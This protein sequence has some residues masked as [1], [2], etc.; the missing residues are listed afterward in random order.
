M[1]NKNQKRKSN[2]IAKQSKLNGDREE[3]KKS[4]QRRVSKIQSLT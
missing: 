1:P 2:V 4:V 3:I